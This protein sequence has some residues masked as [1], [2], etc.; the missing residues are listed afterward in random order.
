[1]SVALTS[2]RKLTFDIT[3]HDDTNQQATD[4]K[5]IHHNDPQK[6]TCNRKASG[7][8]SVPIISRTMKTT[9]AA[10]T[11]GWLSLGGAA[12]F[13]PLQSSRLTS[14]TSTFG[15]PRL[16]ATV[17]EEKELIQELETKT[18]SS[19]VLAS[20]GKPSIWEGVPYEDL[21]IGVL[22]E[23]LAGENRVSQS[24][25]TVRNLVDAG[26]NVVVERGGRSLLLRTMRLKARSA[27]RS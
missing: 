18:V 19:Q 16:F 20:K 11:L 13:V 22:K 6:D 7:S 9:T 10:L 8:R 5:K 23:D 4:E 26:F 27:S 14:P 12:A 3:R 15:R 17:P 21:T 24:P 1:V 25:D 2:V